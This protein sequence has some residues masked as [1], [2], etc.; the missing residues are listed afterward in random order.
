M[1]WGWPA[2]AVCVRCAP[3]RA[4]VVVLVETLAAQVTTAAKQGVHARLRA[5]LLDTRT[6]CLAPF[7]PTVLAWRSGVCGCRRVR[8][9]SRKLRTQGVAAALT[10]HDDTTHTRIQAGVASLTSAAPVTR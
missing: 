9:P 1:G 8:V 7:A 3:A 4:A 10:P 2:A 5:T 6:H